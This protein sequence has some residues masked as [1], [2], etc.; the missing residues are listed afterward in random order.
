MFVASHPRPYESD[1]YLSPVGSGSV[2]Y[3]PREVLRPDEVTDSLAYIA[4]SLINRKHGLGVLTVMEL[5]AGAAPFLSLLAYRVRPS[6]ALSLLGVD[7]APN[8]VGFARY[9][10][11][12]AL[13]K[14]D[15]PEDS[16]D[17]DCKTWC[18][19]LDED[20]S[21][22]VVYFNPPYLKHGN[23]VRDDYVD[24]PADSMFVHAQDPLV[25][26]AE[27]MPRL[28]KIVSSGGLAVVRTPR[29]QSDYTKVLAIAEE[30]FDSHQTTIHRVRTETELPGRQGKGLI[31]EF[32]DTDPQMFSIER[33][34][35]I[36]LGLIQRS[37][38]GIESNELRYW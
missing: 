33:V 38:P 9:N 34:R 10:V 20:T 5:G 24:M 11:S 29:K 31:I 21:Y 19:V 3:N 1:M 14:H 8:S 22:D 36:G 6:I 35:T 30:S 37:M 28:S 25:H 18:E 26:Y 13:R 15:N 12:A 2:E 23:N 27:V 32:T 4:A 7:N 17:I 16:M